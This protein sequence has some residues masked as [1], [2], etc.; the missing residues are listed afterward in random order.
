MLLAAVAGGDDRA[1]ERLIQLLYPELRRRAAAYMR[2]ERPDHTLQATALVHEVYLKLL[3][4]R[5]RWQNRSHFLGVAAQQMRRI[6]VDHARKHETAKRGSGEKVQLK[7]ALAM[8]T[9]HPADLIAVH[10]LLA[11]LA[12]EHQRQA[13]V[14]E[15]RFFGGL[16]EDE[17]ARIV[18]VSVESV[19]RD[20]RFSK[21]WLAKHLRE[22][23]PQ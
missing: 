6:L 16:T 22:P 20:W 8:T 21:A 10:E 13:K 11:R 2:R 3:P 15:L 5:V 19:K 1:R 17:I 4:Q 9:E 14:V 12:E 23:D 7:D 18:N